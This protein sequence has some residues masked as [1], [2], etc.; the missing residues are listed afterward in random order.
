MSVISDRL[1]MRVMVPLFCVVAIDAIGMGVIL[2]LLPFYSQH[3]GASPLAIGAL[4]AVFSLGQLVA[5]PI[6]G[7][8]SDRLGRKVVML[9]SLLGSFASMVLLA[10][11][12]NLLMVF[13]ARIVDGVT[14]GNLSVASAYAIDHSSPQN[15]R[16]AISMIG[17]AIGVGMMAGPLLAA[18]LSQ[19]SISA[20]IWGAALLSALSVV[21]N[22]VFLPRDEKA[23]PA[24]ARRQMPS[25]RQIVLSPR[26]LPV[27]VVLGLFYF[28]FAMYVSQFALFLHAHYAWNGTA[29]G[30]REVGYIFSASGIISIIVQA[31]G[32]QKLERIIPEN[33]LAA[34]SL[35][36]FSA[37]LGIFSM[38]PGL[39]PLAIGILMAS[40]G[41]TMSRPTLMAALSMTSSAQQQG[42]LMG[43]NTSLMAVCNIIAPLIA[44][45]LIDHGLYFG[46]ALTIAAVIAVGAC[47]TLFLV[48]QKKWPSHGHAQAAGQQRQ[49]A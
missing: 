36:L 49:I 11:A 33:L 42:A 39:A 7:A 14:A 48:R 32:M 26:T 12:G 25:L 10:S 41:T 29:F 19:I 43:L 34:V 38:L 15:R 30:P 44:G 47:C 18:G 3:F 20:P 35:L 8:L 17:A 9:A 23:R 2:P 22:L 31:A 28:G 16:R 40:I 5:A 27:L 21:V 37:G 46:W 6:L 45:A 1:P 4:M 24:D 13:L